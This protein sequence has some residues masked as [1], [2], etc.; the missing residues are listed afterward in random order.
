MRISDTADAYTPTGGPA[1]FTLDLDTTN[2]TFDG[3]IEDNVV[4]RSTAT[5]A[6]QRIGNSARDQYSQ[7][8]LSGITDYTFTN[9]V[10]DSGF[11]ELT[12]RTGTFFGGSWDL[13]DSD[14]DDAS[15]VTFGFWGDFV[16][17]WFWINPLGGLTLNFEPEGTSGTITITDHNDVTNRGVFEWNA[18]TDFTT[19][20][21]GL[22]IRADDADLS[23]GDPP[24]D[25]TFTVTLTDDGAQV[26]SKQILLHTNQTNDLTQTFGITANTATNIVEQISEFAV[27]GRTSGPNSSYTITDPSGSQT[28]SFTGYS[29]EPLASVTS[30]LRD[31]VNAA[32]DMPTNFT[33]NALD[34]EIL[35]KPESG[36]VANDWS[37]LVNHGSGNDGTIGYAHSRPNSGVPTSGQMSFPDDIYNTENGE[38]E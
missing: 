22:R 23:S 4:A 12:R 29:R 33:A 34:G 24:V 25:A 5:E 26:P 6:L 14:E 9:A 37:I 20:G 8:T 16:N 2:L 32:T 19:N 3:T 7:I 30:R 31:A 35:L 1:S 38:L 13:R 17:R 28:M 10:A 15:S 36:L 11:T 18:I 21:F 27:G